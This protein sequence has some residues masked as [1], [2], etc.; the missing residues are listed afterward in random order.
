MPVEIRCSSCETSAQVTETLVGNMVRCQSCHEAFLAVE[1]VPLEVGE[2]PVVTARVRSREDDARY[3]AEFDDEKYEDRPRPRRKRRHR[4]DVDAWLKYPALGL[5]IVALVA[6]FVG[7]VLIL[8]NIAYVVGLIVNPPRGVTVDAGPLIVRLLVSTMVQIV[9]LAAWSG[10]VA[11]GA[12]SMSTRQDYY[13]A[14]IGAVVAML[15]CSP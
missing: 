3:G 14:L 7:F 4:L 8:M 9:F 5:K 15:P 10:A 13:V 12:D 6:G 2:E 11:K 1:I